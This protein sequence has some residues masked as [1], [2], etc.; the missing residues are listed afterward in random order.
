MPVTPGS[1]QERHQR[2][3][4]RVLTPQRRARHPSSDL[5]S[6]PPGRGTIFGQGFPKEPGRQKCSSAGGYRTR[7]C[8]MAGSLTLIRK[9]A[10]ARR[11]TVPLRP[12]SYGQMLRRTHSQR[13][14]RAALS[15]AR[16][17]AP[18]R[19]AER[20]LEDVC[21][22]SPHRAD[23][24]VRMSCQDLPLADM[25]RDQVVVT[26][27]RLAVL[28]VRDSATCRLGAAGNHAD[29]TCG[30]VQITRYVQSPS[31]SHHQTLP[32]DRLM[33]EGACR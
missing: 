33:A 7:V 15:N 8:R 17:P 25:K 19:R 11:A 6:R 24:A 3:N 10:G 4:K 29:D 13:C 2:P 22:A 23:E 28:R 9:A 26:S 27:A 1:L 18:A 16:R 30:H 20:A 14:H 32:E 31:L 21:I 5:L 12:A